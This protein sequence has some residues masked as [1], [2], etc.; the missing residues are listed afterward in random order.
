MLWS[1]SVFLHMQNSCVV[2]F[3]HFW[4]KGLP[5][6]GPYKEVWGKEFCLSNGKARGKGYIGTRGSAEPHSGRSSASPT[7]NSESLK[8][9][10][11]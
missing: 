3:L 9:K 7:S 6:S 8:N 5:H 1:K 2:F 11:V 10:T 4:V